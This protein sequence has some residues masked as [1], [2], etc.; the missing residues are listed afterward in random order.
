MAIANNGLD[1]GD[2]L[3]NAKKRDFLNILLWSSIL[4][5]GL[6]RQFPFD[7]NRIF[8]L[9]AVVLELL[10]FLIWLVKAQSPGSKTKKL[11]A[12]YRIDP[13]FFTLAVIAQFVCAISVG[14]PL[15]ETWTLGFIVVAVFFQTITRTVEEIVKSMSQAGFGLICICWALLLTPF[16][17]K[18]FPAGYSINPLGYRFMGILAHPN[19]LG[20]VAIVTLALVLST[21]KIP[22]IKVLICLVTLL[23]TE[24][25]GGIVAALVLFFMW[26]FFNKFP[27]KRIIMFIGSIA[28]ILV[29][30]FI[31]TPREK[32]SDTLTGR[33]DIWLICTRLI[34]D[35]PLHGSGPKTIEK[36][37]GVDTVEWFR[38]FH[39]HNQLLDDLTNYGVL[40]GLFISLGL[41]AFVVSKLKK[42]EFQLAFLFVSVM[43]C[44]LFESPVRL[45]ASAGYLFLPILIIS[46]SFA[47]ARVR[48]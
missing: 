1:Y 2:S 26:G 23:A 11:P 19:L 4:L 31:A 3:D 6:G 37:Y 43:V 24:Y 34:G 21:K 28:A 33:S 27:F 8:L 17:D 29:L 13:W 36:L 41:I 48:S 25:R 10:V 40:G 45:F 38:P 46:C 30:A 44:G 35:K 12:E 18:S 15:Q 16:S 32:E 47:R 22:W 20:I 14:T 42:K 7:P 5:L 9:S 39:C